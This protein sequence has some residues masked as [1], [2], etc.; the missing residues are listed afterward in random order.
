MLY[1]QGLRARVACLFVCLALG[2]LGGEASGSYEKGTG[3]RVP[4]L[5]SVLPVDGG[6]VRLSPAVPLSDLEVA[7]GYVLTAKARA[8]KVWNGWSLPQLVLSEAERLGTRLRFT[9]A[10]GLAI[11]ANFVDDPFVPS[12]VGS[13][14]GLIRAD[15]GGDSRHDSE[16][17][18]AIRVSS[19]GEFSGVVRVGGG[20]W[21]LRGMFDTDGEARFGEGFEREVL[22][23]RVPLA[24][25]VLS[26]RL[27]LNPA[28]ERRI[29][30][31]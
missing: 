17:A 22:L 1:D 8:G 26:L 18:V 29:S 23:S 6:T 25:Y 30:G 13:F 2:L 19:R 28:G 27:D 5:L 16:G 21:V 31:E 14:S 3:D 4:L 20:R 9:M 24:G 11:S 15:V 7:K 12:I 10:P